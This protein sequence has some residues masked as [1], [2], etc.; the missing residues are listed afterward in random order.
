MKFWEH[1]TNV[2]LKKRAATVFLTLQGKAREAILEIDPDSLNVD[3][4]MALLYEKLDE[5]FKVDEDQAALTAYEKF[6]NY[7]RSPEMKISEYRVEFDRLVER[8][9]LTKS[10]C[11]NQCWHIE[12]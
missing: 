9:S 2:A 4:G 12:P 11:L 7:S 8:S 10:T 3:T 5:L 1:A 6:E